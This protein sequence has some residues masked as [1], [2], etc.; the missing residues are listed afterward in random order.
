[1]GYRRKKSPFSLQK[2]PA[3]K[4]EAAKKKKERDT[5]ISITASSEM[6]MINPIHFHRT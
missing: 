5:A 1:M 2:R 6:R 4:L 3:N